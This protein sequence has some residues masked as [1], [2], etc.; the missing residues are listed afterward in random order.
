MEQN[1]HF[2]DQAIDPH[3]KFAQVTADQYDSY[4]RGEYDQNYNDRKPQWDEHYRNIERTFVDHI[5][6][7]TERGIRRSDMG[8]AVVGPGFY[9][10]GKEFGDIATNTVLQDLGRLVMVDFSAEV[11]RRSMENVRENVDELDLLYG[12]QFDLTD[13]YS[14]AYDRF[15]S[16][17]IN[18][19]H[20]E[21]DFYDMADEFDSLGRDDLRKRLNEVLGMVEQEKVEAEHYPL[22][23]V[24]IGG[25]INQY[26][27]LALTS[28]GTP[29]DI[30]TW[31][32]PMVL[33][34]MGAAAEHRIW[35]HFHTITSDIERGAEIDCDQ[36]KENRLIA[37]QK[38]Y[39]LISQ[40]NSIVAT[41]AVRDILKYNP[42]SRVLAVTDTTTVL[43][44]REKGGTFPRLDMHQM[45]VDL[46]NTMYDSVH[47]P[48]NMITL[49]SRWRWKDEPDHGHDI[50]VVEF[51]RRLGVEAN[52]AGEVAI[53]NPL[54]PDDDE[55]TGKEHSHEGE[56]D[57]DLSTVITTIVIPR[58]LDEGEEKD[59]DA[60]IQE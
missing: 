59:D 44:G 1:Y 8:I 35:E 9:P 21:K 5:L 49:P 28:K 31:F 43:R 2:L 13:V 37:K 39:R 38:I 4:L 60:T 11:V 6:S 24:L 56:S 7:Q 34:G 53:V 58:Y 10:I 19:V 12:M 50:A 32:M 15:I 57:D 25:Q 33:A 41:K 55:P 54:K 18:S 26:R 29:V 51:Y 52:T 42:D 48:I 17:R 16:D 3:A 46:E 30:H 22:P 14:T 40:F 47:S 23:D 20:T 45:Q 36:T 27:S